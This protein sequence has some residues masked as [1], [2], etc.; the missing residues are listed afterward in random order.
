[1]LILHC[2]LCFLFL[3]FYLLPFSLFE[4]VLLTIIFATCFLFFSKF[5]NFYLGR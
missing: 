4:T 5:V 2:I 1:M 3:A